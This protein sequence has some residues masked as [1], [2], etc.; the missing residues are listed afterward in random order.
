MALSLVCK[1][2]NT[3]LK[4][5]QEAQAHNEATGH[6]SFEEST[7]AVRLSIL[8]I[9]ASYH[10]LVLTEAI[11]IDQVLNMTCTE[12]GKPCR[13]ET[14]RDLHTKRTGHAGFVDKVSCSCQA[15]GVLWI[16]L[17]R[18]PSHNSSRVMQTSAGTD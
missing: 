11:L 5:V 3:Q 6:T 8:I 9:T 4:N 15:T 12:C 16:L 1:E 17:R 7:E 10:A 2:C 13:S 18:A 14:E